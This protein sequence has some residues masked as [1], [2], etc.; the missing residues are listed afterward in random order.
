MVYTSSYSWI[1]GLYFFQ[2]L[3]QMVYVFSSSWI[4]DSCFSK[5]MDKIIPAFSN[6]WI[7]GFL[8]LLILGYNFP[9]LHV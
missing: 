3:A 8:L 9:K 1:N 6:S 5:F 7:K 4:N 2:F